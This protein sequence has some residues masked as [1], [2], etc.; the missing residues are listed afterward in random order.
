MV[1]AALAI[2]VAVGIAILKYR[3]YDID[4][5]INRTLVYGLLT[6]STVASYLFLVVTFGWLVRLA[7]GQGSSELAVAAT[8]L[9]VAALFQPARLWIQAAVDRR[10]YRARYDATRTL[11]AFQARLRDEPDLE[12]LC[13]ETLRVVEATVRP[14]SAQIWLRGTGGMQVDENLVA[15]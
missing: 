1:V 9:V 7:S 5:I 6:A 11:E 3:L 13:R 14:S 15:P 4:V 10:F 8:T 2:P 12:S